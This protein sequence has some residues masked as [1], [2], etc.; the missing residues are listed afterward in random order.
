MNVRE[1]I[2]PKGI[3]YISEWK[4]FS[5]PE[6]P[7]I[8]DKQIPGCGFT[9]WCITNEMN[10]ILVS[11]RKILLENKEEQ[12]LGEVCL[13]KGILKE[14][15]VDIDLTTTGKKSYAKKEMSQEEKEE[16]NN[17][18]RRN[19]EFM[20]K[21]VIDYCFYRN[22]QGKPCKILV[23]YDSYR[24]VRE[25]LEEL[26]I[27]ESFY[28]VVDE[29][30][31]IFI[32]SRFKSNTEM[33]F[34]YA[35]QGVQRVCFVS[36]T[37]M[38][39]EYLD[40]LDEFKDL[41]YTKLDWKKED[42]GRVATPGL[43]VLVLKSLGAVAD[44]IIGSYLSGDF[45]KSGRILP[46]GR[47]EEVISKEAVIYVN[48]VNNI[49]QII[50]RTGLKPDQVNIL[51]A[52]TTEN[53]NRIRRKLGSKFSIGKVPL[54]GEKN[55][56][57]TL[58]TRTVYL[59][60]DFY[61]DNA[62]TFVIS[63]ANIECLAVDITLD[64][65]QILGRQRLNENPWKNKA[66]IYA[67]VISKKNK[68]DKSVFDRIL[69]T[70]FEATQNL[71]SIYEKGDMKEKEILAIKYEKDAKN[72]SYKDDYVAVNRHGGTNL[73]PKFNNLVMISEQRAFDIQQ[74]D[75]KD[76]F[77]VFNRIEDNGSRLNNKVDI[78]S[79]LFEFSSQKNQMEKM[80]F[81]CQLDLPESVLTI[82]L[83]RVPEYYK[84]F[85]VVLG[86]ERC[87]AL[88]YCYTK[89]NRDCAILSFNKS[90]LIDRIFSTFS[91]GDKYSNQYVKETL[92]N[93]YNELGYAKTPKASDLEEYF[94]VKAGKLFDSVK[95]KWVHGIELVNKKN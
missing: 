10:M 29:F 62:R 68:V 77:S 89:M 25:W 73:F 81:L 82:I 30:Q 6:F 79:I 91:V 15:G 47:R 85:Y 93:I 4:E 69:K 31:S 43:D 88:G 80:K 60:A 37:P 41:P 74:V 63:D 48:S 13:V 2:V 54:R 44:K 5:L 32:D 61:S 53:Q 65:P 9:E 70:K 52:D 35:L 18:V 40:M 21:N 84:R 39:E 76:R 71:L 16:F 46:D 19:Y 36:A 33:E 45:V 86:P 20:K 59:G 17:A 11:P 66:T 38:I 75:Y 27:F 22:S 58:C 3:R 72:S 24:K 57:F 50:K 87:R 67:K 49:C 55:K 56:M 1:L 83:D 64:L 92:G 23:T 8:I 14:L 90:D 78:D 7:N 26:G 12:H 51:C 42:S 28:T 95:N 34:L 94:E